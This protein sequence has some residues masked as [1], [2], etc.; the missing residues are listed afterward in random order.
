MKKQF[1]IMVLLVAQFQ[2]GWA[3]S[4]ATSSPT[5]TNEEEVTD[6]T[7]IDRVRLPRIFNSLCQ[8]SE[9]GS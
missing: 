9:R 6:L 3:Q 7:T 8:G 1:L 4:G 5:S 2:I